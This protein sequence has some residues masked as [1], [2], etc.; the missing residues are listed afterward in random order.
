MKYDAKLKIDKEESIKII[1]EQIN[2]LK[3]LENISTIKEEFK[4]IVRKINIIMDSKEVSERLKSKAIYQE[5]QYSIEKTK[6][7]I[8]KAKERISDY[9]EE[10]LDYIKNDVNELI[11]DNNKFSE[12]VAIRIIKNILNN[13][14]M[15]I[16]TMYEGNVHK[17]AGITK[18]DLEK[19][20]I[21]NEYDVQRILY[22]LIKPIFPEARVEVSNDTGFS[23]IRYDIFIEKFSIVIEVKCSRTSMTERGLTEEIGSDIFHYKYTNIFFF[24]YDKEKI[25]KNRTSFI[26]TYNGIFDCKNISTII[27]QPKIL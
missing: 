9:L 15:H 2:L 17:K 13:F 1:N 12:E 6:E 18:E 20:K 21:V 23:T 25:I 10:I 8:L 14:Y 4:G 19:I 16:E 24:I 3:N 11:S 27:I 22:S 7:N 5:N 26:N